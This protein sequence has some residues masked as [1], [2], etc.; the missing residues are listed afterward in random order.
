MCIH[1]GTPHRQVRLSSLVFQEV[2]TEPR[3]CGQVANDRCAP[4]KTPKGPQ[5]P[6]IVWFQQQPAGGSLSLSPNGTLSSA[7]VFCTQ[8]C[9]GRGLSGSSCFA[10]LP[11]TYHHCLCSHMVHFR[12]N[13]RLLEPFFLPSVPA[14]WDQQ[15]DRSGFLLLLNCIF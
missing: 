14:T 2:D 5:K 7:S 13:T 11:F 3:T 10:Q 9:P 1:T 12:G 4:R 6:A 8:R 15:E